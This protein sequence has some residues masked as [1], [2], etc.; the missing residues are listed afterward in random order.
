METKAIYNHDHE[1]LIDALNID[2][3]KLEYIVRAMEAEEG[4]QEF[5][6]SQVIATA[7]KFSTTPEELAWIA[8][9]LGE[10]A[11]GSCPLKGAKGVIIGPFNSGDSHG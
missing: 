9:K 1:E 11:C 6:Q 10:F 4:E 8:T 7:I 5:T 2:R 3:E